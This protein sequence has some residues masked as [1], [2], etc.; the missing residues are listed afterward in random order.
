LEVF[1]DRADNVIVGESDGDNHSFS[2]DEAFKGHN[3]YEICRETGEGLVN[4]SKRPS[5]I[6]E[7]KIKGKNVKVRFPF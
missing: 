1:K 3:M 4:L 2:A 7:D 5:R 6:V